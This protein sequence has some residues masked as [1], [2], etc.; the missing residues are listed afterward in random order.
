MIGTVKNNRE[1]YPRKF[2]STPEN[3]TR[4]KFNPGLSVNR[5][6]NNWAQMLLWW[7]IRWGVFLYLVGYF[8]IKPQHIDLCQVCFARAKY[9]LIKQNHPVKGNVDSGIREI[10]CSRRIRIPAQGIRNPTNVWLPESKFTNKDW[11][12]SL[13]GIRTPQ[14]GI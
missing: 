5:P 2:F 11:S 12:Q 8:A 9:L 4:V 13:A 1:N 6:S 7:E 14:C 3:K 10:S